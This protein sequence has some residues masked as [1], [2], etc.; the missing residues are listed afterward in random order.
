MR[1]RQMKSVKI[2]IP[3]LGKFLVG[4]ILPLSIIVVISLTTL[5]ALLIA[6]PKMQTAYAISFPISQMT[7][8][9]VLE[10]MKNMNRKNIEKVEFLTPDGIV[11]SGPELSDEVMANVLSDPDFRAQ[12]EELKA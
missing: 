10:E 11:E 5:D 8:D 2:Q 7:T 1:T 12:V 9:E 3:I 4:S 6:K